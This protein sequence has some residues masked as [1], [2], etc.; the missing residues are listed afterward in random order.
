[1]IA[2]NA[3]LGISFLSSRKFGRNKRNIMDAIKKRRK[4]SRKRGVTAK[5]SFIMGAERPQRIELAV[6]AR[7]ASFFS[8]IDVS[9]LK[10]FNPF[11]IDVISRVVQEGFQK[12]NFLF[13]R[14]HHFRFSSRA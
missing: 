6:N 8:G 9:F 5:R 14:L 2:A 7:S 12:I 3:I 1:M 13:S 10:N 4:A 11:I